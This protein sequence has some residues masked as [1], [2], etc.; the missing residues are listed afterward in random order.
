M[1]PA[2]HPQALFCI[3]SR[4]SF[5]SILNIAASLANPARPRCGVRGVYAREMVTPIA[6]AMREIGFH[7]ALVYHGATGNGCGGIDE[8]SPVA[9]SYV[10]ELTED[11]DILHFTVTPREAGLRGAFSLREIAAGADTREEAQRLLRV[12]AGTDKGAVYETVCLNTAPILYVT[13][14]ASS[15]KLGVEAAR[16][17]IDSGRALQKLQQ[18]V[19]EQNR[20]RNSG[21]VVLNA[22]LAQI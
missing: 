13:G 12:F 20:D 17:M 21:T 19:A 14:A 10:A 1:S 3:L 9:E 8:L 22:M 11:G 16:E 15:L 5:G 2:V 6:E 4:M 7:R 18:W